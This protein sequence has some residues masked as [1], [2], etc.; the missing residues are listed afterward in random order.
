MTSKLRVI[1]VETKPLAII[2]ADTDE[3]ARASM[4]YQ[5]SLNDVFMVYTGVLAIV[6]NINTNDNTA[7]CF[8]FT[9]LEVI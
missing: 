7:G 3:T 5:A 8:A 2:A 6:N 1:I 9:A 4:K